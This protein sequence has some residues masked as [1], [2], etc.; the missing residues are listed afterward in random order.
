MNWIW[1]PDKNRSNQDKHRISFE[2]AQLVFLDTLAVTYPDPYPY[3]SRWRTIGVVHSLTLVVIYSW[4]DIDP[5]TGQSTSPGRIISARR[6]TRIEQR[7]YEEG[8]F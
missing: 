2:T 5:E 1:D 8:D 3:E 6:A 4:P 7:T